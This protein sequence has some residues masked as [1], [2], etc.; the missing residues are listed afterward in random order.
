MAQLLISLASPNTGCPVLRV[1][2]EGWESGCWRKFVDHAAV[3]HKS[4]STGSIASHPYKERK[5]GAIHF[6]GDGRKIK[7]PGPALTT[8][9]PWLSAFGDRD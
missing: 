8:Y 2:C 7:K 9:L 3:Y 4:S 6:V 1:L 5:D